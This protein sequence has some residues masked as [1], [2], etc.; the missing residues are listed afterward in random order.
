MNEMTPA[1]QALSIIGAG[2]LGRSIDA[3]SRSKGGI[4]LDVTLLDR[5]FAGHDFSD[6]VL[7][8]CVPDRQIVPVADQ[9]ID[10]GALPR[11]IGHTSGATSLEPLAEA[12]T[13]GGAF[14]IHPLQ[15]VP[16]EYT[17]LS[18]SSAAVAGSDASTLAT[19]EGLARALGMEPFEVDEADRAL[20]HAAASIASNFLV[21]LEQT[22]AEI[23]E[24]ISV[25]EPRRVLMPLI[26]QSIDNWG[27]DGAAALTGPIVRGDSETVAAHRAAIS[28]SRP[29]L[30]GLYDAMAERTAA[31][32][33]PQENER[34]AG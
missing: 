7:L 4:G 22:A 30:L 17:D 27:R 18:G 5:D 31:I 2:R 16:N 25:K 3:F 20:Y 11:M 32:A 14:S 21:T 15:T 10:A 33:V 12:H 26:R 13:G 1:P 9:L 28:G 34:A 24:G 29:E 6:E 19:A 8:L 23:L